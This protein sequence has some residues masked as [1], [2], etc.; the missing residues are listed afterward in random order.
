MPSQSRRDVE[1]SWIKVI[2]FQAGRSESFKDVAQQQHIGFDIEI[3]LISQILHP[4][5]SSNTLSMIMVALIDSQAHCRMLQL[6]EGGSLRTYSN[7]S[8][9][10]RDKLPF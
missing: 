3:L 4:K 5:L 7:H 1:V 8:C 9:I 2:V 6:E 10:H